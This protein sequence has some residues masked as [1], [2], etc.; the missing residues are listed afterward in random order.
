MYH[1]M[2]YMDTSIVC[3]VN[4]MTIASLADFCLTQRANRCVG[5][6][7][8]TM[9]TGLVGALVPRQPD[10]FPGL[11]SHVEGHVK[12]MHQTPYICKRTHFD[13]F[14]TMNTRA[15]TSALGI[16]AIHNVSIGLADE[17]GSRRP[18]DSFPLLSGEPPGDQ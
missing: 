13:V 2:L 15:D 1:N 11:K 5:D 7:F 14:A 8:V 17:K 4:T 10:L 18:R 12:I 3:R 16:R 9:S 6:V